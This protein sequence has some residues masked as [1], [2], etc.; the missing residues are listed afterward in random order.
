MTASHPPAALDGLVVLDLT[1][2]R[3]N[4]C[5]KLLAELGADV[6]LIEPPEGSE[7]RHHPPFLDD[8]APAEASLRFIYQ[9]TG[10]RSAVLDLGTEGGVEAFRALVTRADVVLESFV[11]GRM[12]DLGLSFEQLHRLNP[13][14]VMASISAFGQSGP[15]SEFDA[16]DLVCLAASGFLSLG[17]YQDG[18]PMRTPDEQGHI[19]AGSFAATAVL[20]A[21]LHSEATGEGQHIDVSVQESMTM[22]LENAAQYYDLEGIIRR[23]TGDAQKQAGTGLFRASDGY[24][25]LMATGIGGNRFWPNCVAWLRG[26]DRPGAEQLAEPKWALASHLDTE[27]AKSAFNDIFA[28]YAFSLTRAELVDLARRHRVPLAAVNSSLEVLDAPQLA[29]RGFPQQLEVAP[30][31]Y[32]KA[33]GAPYLLSATPWRSTGRAPALGEHTD[34]VLAIAA[35]ATASAAAGGAA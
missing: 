9:N 15:F 35:R 8:A 5:G 4:Y 34:A 10:K 21:V 23:R 6:V 18:A 11:P 14:L 24:V 26:E 32:A 19:A 13:R 2:A 22:A 27:Q 17:G 28:P 33:P 3:G 25:Y 29:H 20:M 30:G 31:R 16:P 7:L 1:G 12:H